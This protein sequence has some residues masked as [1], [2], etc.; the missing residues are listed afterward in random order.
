[1]DLAPAAAIGRRQARVGEEEGVR[2]PAPVRGTD[3]EADPRTPSRGEGGR[4]EEPVSRHGPDEHLGQHG[5]RK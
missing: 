1:M 4:P 5:R 2:H 3:Q